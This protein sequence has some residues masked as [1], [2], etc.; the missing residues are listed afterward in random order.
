MKNIESCFFFFLI[1]FKR[2]ARQV[3]YLKIYYQIIREK[4][5][6]SYNDGKYIFK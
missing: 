5:M 4:I 2:L 6:Y 1:V 3:Q